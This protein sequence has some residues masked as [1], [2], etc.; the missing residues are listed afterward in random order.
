MCMEIIVT[1]MATFTTLISIIIMSIMC[2]MYNINELQVDELR[3]FHFRC[4]LEKIQ[5]VKI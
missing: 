2:C 5:I 4:G 1:L 3:E